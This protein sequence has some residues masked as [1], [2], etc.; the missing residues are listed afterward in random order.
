M[1]VK[2]TTMADMDVDQ[3]AA[4]TSSDKGPKKRFEVKKVIV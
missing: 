3:P 4:G 2:E 1:K